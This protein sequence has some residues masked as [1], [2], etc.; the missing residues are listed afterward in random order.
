MG[1][2]DDDKPTGYRY[3]NGKLKADF[4]I[5]RTLAHNRGA[6][7]T[8]KATESRT[9]VSGTTLTAHSFSGIESCRD[10]GTVYAAA[11]KI[12]ED[13]LKGVEQDVKEYQEKLLA[14][15]KHLEHRD[16]SASDVFSA[17]ATSDP[18]RGQALHADEQNTQA[19]S[20]EQ[21]EDAETLQ[22][23]AEDEERG[24]AGRQADDNAPVTQADTPPDNSIGG[25]STTSQTDDGQTQV[26]A[27]R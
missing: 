8:E 27:A 7:W 3:A 13:T 16:H 1:L 14:V 5:I 23:Q 26:K 25:P 6:T 11:K 9:K 22:Q 19:N 24:G 4:E 2:P 20:T 10:F 17:L 21:A 12:Y 15:A 18:S